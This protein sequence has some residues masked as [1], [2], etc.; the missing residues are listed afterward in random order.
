MT[1]ML[2]LRSSDRH[3]RLPNY[4]VGLAKKFVRVCLDQ[5]M[6]KTQMNFLAIPIF[7][8]LFCNSWPKLLLQWEI[9]KQNRR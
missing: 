7:H 1:V 2:V 4:F 9:S 6:E 8:E 5:L 3:M